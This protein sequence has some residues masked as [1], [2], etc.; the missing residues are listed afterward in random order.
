MGSNARDIKILD[1][2]Q[3]LLPEI[4]IQ[5]LKL[6]VKGEVIV[7]GEAPDDVYRAA[8]DRWNKAWIQEAVSH[9][10]GLPALPCLLAVY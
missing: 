10:L 3:Q 7:K 5:E 1:R 4:A 9:L 8:L 2:K 6:S